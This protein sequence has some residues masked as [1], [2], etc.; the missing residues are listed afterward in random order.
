MNPRSLKSVLVLLAQILGPFGQIWVFHK[1]G[2]VFHKFTENGEFYIVRILTIRRKNRDAWPAIKSWW[3]IYCVSTCLFCSIY[4][5]SFQGF[6]IVGLGLCFCCGFLITQSPHVPLFWWGY[7][8]SHI[9]I[10]CSTIQDIFTFW[11]RLDNICRYIGWSDKYNI[12]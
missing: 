2:W 8:S 10:L 1:F 7:R 5:T 12:C 11:S 6:L 3:K 9:F 4:L